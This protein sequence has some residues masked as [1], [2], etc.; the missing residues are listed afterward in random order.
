MGPLPG[1]IKSILD[2][3]DRY[4]TRIAAVVLLGFW[5]WDLLGQFGVVKGISA[6][7][8]AT[9]NTLLSATMVA[10]ILAV[11][12][13]LLRWT[14]FQQELDSFDESA[15]ATSH[16][17]QTAATDIESKIRG[18]FNGLAQARTEILALCARSTNLVFAGTLSQGILEV[19]GE[20]LSSNSQLHIKILDDVSKTANDA[21][22]AQAAV[23]FQ[24]QYRHRVEYWFKPGPSTNDLFIGHVAIKSYR[25]LVLFGG[26][27]TD[28]ITFGLTSDLRTDWNTDDL[29]ESPLVRL[30][31]SEKLPDLQT[32]CTRFKTQCADLDKGIFRVSVMQVEDPAFGQF[33]REAMQY[34]PASQKVTVSWVFANGGITLAQNEK[35]KEWL[36]ELKKRVE[37]DLTFEVRRYVFV[38]FEAISTNANG[39]RDELIA[40]HQQCFP[41]NNRYHVCYLN[42]D[43]KEISE[44]QY[45]YLIFHRADLGDVYQGT[46]THTIGDNTEFVF[47]GQ[48]SDIEKKCTQFFSWIE[49]K[50]EYWKK[51]GVCKTTMVGGSSADGG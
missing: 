19:F 29:G 38:S 24:S 44:K 8:D 10:M 30:N 14:E 32:L 22:L 27:T 40:L 26:L 50:L 11:G 46:N 31:I 9:R 34:L 25:L 3:C 47:N 6:L 49:T 4:V 21:H 12:S 43:V 41:T 48:G 45:D 20:A 23:K 33:W 16:R 18:Y 36:T 28:A 51:T 17:L 35:I 39:I 42:A 15:A 7:P 1:W 2:L 37:D 13:L 5:L